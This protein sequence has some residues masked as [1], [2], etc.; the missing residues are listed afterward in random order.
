VTRTTALEKAA[1]AADWADLDVRLVG[2]GPL[3]LRRNAA[4]E[5]IPADPVDLVDVASGIGMALPTTAL[6]DAID[7]Y[8]ASRA[9]ILRAAKDDCPEDLARQ[10]LTRGH[11]PT[12][13]TLLVAR[14]PWM[15]LTGLPVLRVDRFRRR[16]VAGEVTEAVAVFATWTAMSRLR[17]NRNRLTP[18]AAHSLLDAAGAL[19]GIG[20]YRPAVVV[21]RGVRGVGGFGIFHT[22]G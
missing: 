7:A 15:R 4:T 2:D 16:G 5:G 14:E 8:L 18:A 6:T 1:V 12:A 22:G 20:V 21:P 17:Y 9:K 13:A 11:K 3:A 19:C 10:Y